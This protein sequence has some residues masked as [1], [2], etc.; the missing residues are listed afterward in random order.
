MSLISPTRSQIANRRVPQTLYA[1]TGVCALLCLVIGIASPHVLVTNANI[2]AGAVKAGA[3]LNYPIHIYDLSFAPV[4]VTSY[5]L[6][7]CTAG[8]DVRVPI[9]PFRSHTIRAA[10]DTENMKPGKQTRAVALYFESGK[11]IW[12]QNANITFRVSKHNT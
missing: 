3:T 10:V 7:G 5:P 11:R 2:A 4:L 12:K 8:V 9:P 6:C 1:V